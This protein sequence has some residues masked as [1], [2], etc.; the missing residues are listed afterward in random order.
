MQW[1]LGQFVFK[2]E[3]IYPPELDAGHLA[4]NYDVLILENGIIRSEEP[5]GEFRQQRQLNLESIPPEYRARVGIVS[6]E[7]TIPQLR[8]F[9][10]DGGTILAIGSSTEL[11]YSAG[12]PIASALVDEATA[13]PLPPE[14]FY[15]PGAIFGIRVD[16]LHPL[17]YGMP[18]QIDI[19]YDNNPLFRLKPEARIRPVCWFDSPNPLRSGWA[20][21][22]KYLNGGVAVVE[23]QVG[24][25]RLVLFG[26]LIAFRAHPHGTF[27]LL[28]NGIYY[29]KAEPFKF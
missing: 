16:N 1:L 3:V 18:E 20:W 23:G 19:F 27:K 28:F 14:R 26:P 13:K 10:A 29:G 12:L 22:Q 2:Y 21:G 7:K 24:Q 8:Q 6:K 4:G 25:G 9:L 17:A 11:G 15:A 5:G